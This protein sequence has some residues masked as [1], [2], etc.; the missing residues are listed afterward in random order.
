MRHLTLTCSILILLAGCGG[1]TTPA[2][3]S[4]DS[5][6]QRAAQGADAIATLAETA[7]DSAALDAELD[8]MFAEDDRDLAQLDAAEREA[9]AALREAEAEH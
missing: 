1:E 3:V 8:A 4:P 6:A 5:N 9:E 7:P 2:A